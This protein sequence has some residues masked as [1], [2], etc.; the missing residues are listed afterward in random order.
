VGGSRTGLR[1]V[2]EGVVVQIDDLALRR[3]AGEGGQGQQGEREGV[4]RAR[5]RDFRVP[6]ACGARVEVTTHDVSLS[7]R[8]RDVVN[9]ALR[10]NSSN[11]TRPPSVG[12][13]FFLTA[14]HT[15]LAS[16]GENSHD[17]ILPSVSLTASRATSETPRRTFFPRVFALNAS[18]FVS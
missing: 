11:S 8:E 18:P 17:S 13:R 10:A 12:P 3:H 2:L 6:V 16:W 7:Q 5:H 4:S 14:R 1:V 9:F 15:N